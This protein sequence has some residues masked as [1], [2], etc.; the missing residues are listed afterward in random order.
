MKDIL[1]KALSSKEEIIKDKGEVVLTEVKEEAKIPA[2][3]LDSLNKPMSVNIN[4]KSDRSANLD[5]MNSLKS[6]ISNV[7]VPVEEKK[8]EVKKETIAFEEKPRID[9]QK[10]EEKV[11][12]NKIEFKIP[13]ISKIEEVKIVEKIEIPE[14]KIEEKIEEKK[15]EIK[16]PVFEIPKFDIPKEED[17]KEEKAGTM[18]NLSKQNIQE[19]PEEVLR[20]LFE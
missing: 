12:E 10:T 5:T 4:N 17:K 7:A 1:N 18:P 8:E 13:E 11:L 6:L 3:S 9:T 19:V 15:E 2:M 14:K 16:I 20:K